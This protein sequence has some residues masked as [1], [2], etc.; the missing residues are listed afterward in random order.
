MRFRNLATASVLLLLPLIAHAD[1]FTYNL[2]DVF[3]GFSVM[4]T[5]MTDT[6]SGVLNSSDITGYDILLNDGSATL[7]LTPGNS[8]FELEGSSVTATATGLLF[9]FDNVTQDFL[10]FQSPTLG[11]G[12]NYLCYQG[13]AGGCDD[14][15]D[16][17]ESVWIGDSGQ[18]KE[19]RSGNQQIASMGM[20]VTPEPESLVLLGT[21][22][23]GLVGVVRRRLA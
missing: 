13:A 1:N 11:L 22:V 9:D 15:I 17:H 19:L 10:L 14:F 7:N 5:I 8:Q 2:N 20:A 3:P 4:G 23:L 12:N 21:G 6:N 18:I 16:A